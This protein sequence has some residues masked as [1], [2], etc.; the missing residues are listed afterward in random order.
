MASGTGALGGLAERYAA[1]LYELADEAKALDSVAGDLRALVAAKADSPAL[2]RLIKS[3]A[4]GRAAKAKAIGALLE[5]SGAH[6]LTRRF[7]A[8]LARNGRL[9]ALDGIAKAFLNELARRRGE[10][11]AV[12]SSARQLT[13]D[14]SGALAAALTKAQGGK[15]SIDARVD[16][17][18]LGGLIVRLGSRM[19]DT[20]LKSKLA[21]LQL[22]MKEA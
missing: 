13:S 19:V 5:Q 1:A 20:S 14:Q 18:L 9:N 6:A 8:V 16:P 4:L 11:V 21:R 12:V 10:T 22:A 17:S 7:F 15:V 2:A 3:P